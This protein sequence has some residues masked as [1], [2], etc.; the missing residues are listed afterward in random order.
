MLNIDGVLFPSLCIYNWLHY[1][2]TGFVWFFYNVGI[3]GKSGSIQ[4]Y[5]CY[6]PTFICQG[7]ARC[8]YLLQQSFSSAL[9]LSVAYQMLSVFADANFY[10][11]D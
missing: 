1:T 5:L 3:N 8:L 11:S 9:Q 10:L 2:E 4:R 6:T 7:A